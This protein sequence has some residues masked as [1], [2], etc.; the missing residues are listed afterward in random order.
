[1]LTA[2]V[3][4]AR[5]TGELALPANCMMLAADIR[6]IFSGI[7][8]A[9]RSGCSVGESPQIDKAADPDEELR[10]MSFEYQSMCAHWELGLAHGVLLP[11][12]AAQNHKFLA[13]SQDDTR[14]LRKILGRSGCVLVPR[15]SFDCARWPPFSVAQW[16]KGRW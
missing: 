16:R 4:R 1:M 15:K 2:K 10:R 8:T 6:E 3:T 5:A 13:R 11:V 9:H 7:M 14:L 12:F